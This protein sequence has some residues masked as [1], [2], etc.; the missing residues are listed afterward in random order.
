M[1]LEWSEHYNCYACRLASGAM[2][3]SVAW[4]STAPKGT[5]SGYVVSVAGRRLKELSPNAEHGKQ[6]AVLLARRIL[7][8]IA[9]ELDT[10]AP[11]SGENP[12]P[13]PNIVRGETGVTP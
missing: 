3:L 13:S 6:R 7:A 12:L 1:S 5:P 8:E 9:A 2:T 11:P 4:N 10:A